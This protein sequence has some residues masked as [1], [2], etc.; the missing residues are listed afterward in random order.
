MLRAMLGSSFTSAPAIVL[1]VIGAL[2]L[3]GTF[4]EQQYKAWSWLRE[5]FFRDDVDESSPPVLLLR[6]PSP[7]P[8]PRLPAKPFCDDQAT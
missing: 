1:Y 4:V 5:R 3:V 2:V 8:P 6:Q 7:P